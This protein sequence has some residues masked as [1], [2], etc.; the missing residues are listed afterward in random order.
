MTYTGKEQ[1]M[2]KLDKYLD[3][4][5]AQISKAKSNQDILEREVVNYVR[6]QK[7]LLEGEEAHRVMCNHHRLVGDKWES[8]GSA[9]CMYFTPDEYAEWCN[10]GGD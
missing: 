7:L 2:T 4:L 6:V 10:T 3:V 8:V 1:T 5:N 9:W